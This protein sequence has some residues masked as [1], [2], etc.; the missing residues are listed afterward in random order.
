MRIYN[1]KRQSGKTTSLID[2]VEWVN[3]LYGHGV[4]TIWLIVSSWAMA[5]HI[6]LRLKESDNWTSN[7]HV[8]THM[9]HVQYATQ[10]DFIFVDEYQHCNSELVQWIKNRY[11]DRTVM[12]GTPNE[13]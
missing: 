4:K 7:I 2:Q 8:H 10:P 11:S 1:R 5:K 3:I 9:G 12:W 6:E 13:G